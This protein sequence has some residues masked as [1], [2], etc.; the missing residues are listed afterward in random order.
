ML[1]YLDIIKR[2]TWFDLCPPLASKQ[3]LASTK[4]C[5]PGLTC[6][7][8]SS[9][10]LLC[11]WSCC[12]VGWS[13]KPARTSET[14]SNLFTKK[15]PRCT[16]HKNPEGPDTTWCSM[17][18]R[19]PGF[20]PRSH[21]DLLL[22]PLFLVISSL[23]TSPLLCQPLFF[24]FLLG[25]HPF[26]L[27]F[28]LPLVFLYLSVRKRSCDICSSFTTSLKCSGMLKYLDII[29]R[30]TWFDLCPPLASKQ[31]LASTKGCSPGLTCRCRSSLYLLCMWSCCGVG[32]S[33][34]PARTSET[35][36][37]LSRKKRPRCKVHKNPERLNTT[38][39]LMGKRSPGFS[40]GSVPISCRNTLHLPAI[41]GN[42]I[43]IWLLV[44]P[45][46]L[47]QVTWGERKHAWVPKTCC[48]C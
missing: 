28:L 41:P 47:I 24:F 40:P 8:R 11:M 16:V 15:R 12:G 31:W 20:S 30:E 14:E 3:W 10:Y 17:G 45:V 25:P 32:W 5:S 2:E 39:Y 44:D 18:K 13:P 46:H 9:L 37:N 22:P 48:V 33:P 42:G 7:C 6:R 36:R 23:H 43:P 35:E 21:L 27:L 38:W 4:G 19:S 34:K 26:S 29:K 1:K